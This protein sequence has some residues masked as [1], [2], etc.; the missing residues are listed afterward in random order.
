MNGNTNTLAFLGGFIG[1]MTHYVHSLHVLL[2][3]SIR[4]LF[5]YSI[6]SLIGGVIMLAV[7]LAGDWLFR[8]L[9]R[10]NNKPGETAL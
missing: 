8:K 5:D 9:N 10:K 3:I 2:Q 1:A 6:H 4:E 7:K